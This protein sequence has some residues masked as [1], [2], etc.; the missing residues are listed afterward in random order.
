MRPENAIRQV[1]AG[2]ERFESP[3]RTLPRRENADVPLLM[4]ELESFSTVQVPSSPLSCC[5]PVRDDLHARHAAV[6]LI[7]KANIIPCTRWLRRKSHACC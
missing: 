2:T 6:G 4:L 5:H 3:S 7:T 1:G